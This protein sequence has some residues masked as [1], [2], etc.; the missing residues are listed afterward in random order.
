MNPEELLSCY[1]TDTQTRFSVSSETREVI[2]KII[3]HIVSGDTLEE[4]KTEFNNP[5]EY[6]AY[7]DSHLEFILDFFDKYHRIYKEL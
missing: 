4:L 3:S 7:N 6:T 1:E 5:V 2:L